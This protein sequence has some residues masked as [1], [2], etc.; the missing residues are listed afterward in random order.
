MSSWTH[1]R[2][3]AGWLAVVAM[4]A[5]ASPGVT[6]VRAGE[7]DDLA[8]AGSGEA[9]VCD[10]SAAPAA[11]MNVTQMIEQLRQQAEAEAE[12][13][14]SDPDFVVLN[15]RGFNYGTPRDPDPGRAAV[16]ATLPR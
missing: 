12:G 13:G 15:N 2:N 5:L 10:P 11:V 16:D 4:V 14:T 7:G 6:P 3:T 9:A 8:G 1:A